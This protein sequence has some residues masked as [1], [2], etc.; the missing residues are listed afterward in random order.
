MLIL[1]SEEYANRVSESFQE[2]RVQLLSLVG[3]FKLIDGAKSDKL[4]HLLD[5]ISEKS[6]PDF[7]AAIAA[8]WTAKPV[9]FPPDWFTN[10]VDL[11]S[12]RV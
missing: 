7:V 12:Y 3:V 6:A 4:H 1:D 11:P 9:I 8:F 2:K 10:I 5:V